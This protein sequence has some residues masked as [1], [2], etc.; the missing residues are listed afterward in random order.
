MNKTA[1]RSLGILLVVAAL[2]T[3]IWWASR[4]EP[5]AVKVAPVESGSVERTVANTRAGTIKACRRARL[6]PSTGGQIA[7]LPVAEGDA[8]QQGQ[9][10]LELW[11]R[12]L[13]AQ[14]ELA[15]QEADS[16]TASS[17]AKCIEADQ[18][19]R[20]STRLQS[21]LK[22]KLV[23]EEQADQA[24]TGARAGA[25]A[26]EA[27]QANA[28]VARSRI[29]V[30]QANLDK[31]RLIAPFDGVVAEINGELSEFVTP[32]PIGIPTPPAVDLIANDCFY[33]T[34]PIDEVDVAGVEVGQPARVTLDAFGERV[35]DGK[36]RRIADYVLDVEKQARTVDV[37]I[38]LADSGNT[39]RLLA[40]YS[41]DVEIVLE[42]HHDTLRIPTEALLES[43]QVYVFD[44]QQ[45]TLQQRKVRTGIANWDQTEVL[46]GLSAGEQVVTA[47]DRERLADGV[48]AR[49][50]KGDGK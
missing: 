10:L 17:L 28:A 15:R 48:A 34:A 6:S 13:E 26:C 31:T 14:L 42:V 22:R 5:V 19:A 12:D 32:S 36:V 8:V 11:N 45:Q 2:G 23:S 7:K 18:A 39:E 49:I 30:A 3:W 35:L 27:A 37:E 44:A 47:V 41:A 40:G 1:R 4:P 21:L 50:D 24:L 29:G 16:A 38:E 33:M 20:E 43:D 25:A 9:L 46:E